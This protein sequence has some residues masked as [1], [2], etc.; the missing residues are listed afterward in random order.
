LFFPEKNSGGAGEEFF[1]VLWA[2]LR[3]LLGRVV[4]RTWFLGGELVVDCVVNLVERLSLGWS[5]KIGHPRKVFLGIR[6]QRQ[7]DREK[8]P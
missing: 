4:C 6:E 8:G 5:R 1:V 7:R 2:F 3:G